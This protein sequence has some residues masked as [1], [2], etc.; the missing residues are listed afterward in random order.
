MRYKNRNTL[1]VVKEERIEI[2]VEPS[3]KREIE[4]AAAILGQTVS[5]F[6][7]STSVSDA[8]A[9]IA[10]HVRTE[11][12]L[13]DWKRFQALLEKPAR[14]TAALKKAVRRY[15]TSAIRSHGL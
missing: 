10:E 11:L 1:R 6:I 9:V 3:I 8:R 15:K 4:R 14:P 7:V 12:S 2:R 13:A 5:A